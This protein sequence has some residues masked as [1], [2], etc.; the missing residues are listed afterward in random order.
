MCFFRHE[1]A[2]GNHFAQIQHDGGT[3]NDRVKYQVLAV[4]LVLPEWANN[5]VLC[6]GLQPL[7]SGTA[8]KVGALFN[9]L[10]YERTGFRMADVSSYVIS[11]AAALS[12]AEE[13]DLGAC[14]RFPIGDN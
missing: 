14:G 12:V 6:L 5:L 8:E 3:L 13:I 9:R 10:F 2:K 1:E 4:Q 7:S 11:D